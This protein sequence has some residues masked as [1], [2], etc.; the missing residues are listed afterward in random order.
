MLAACSVHSYFIHFHFIILWLPSQDMTAQNHPPRTNMKCHKFSPSIHYHSDVV[1][2]ISGYL[3]PLPP[4]LVHNKP[5]LAHTCVTMC[6]D[7]LRC[8]T[9]CYDVLLH[10]ML[11]GA[12]AALKRKLGLG[13]PSRFRMLQVSGCYTVDNEGGKVDDAREFQEM[14]QSMK[15]VGFEDHARDDMLTLLAAILHLSN[16]SFTPN[17][18]DESDGAAADA[19]ALQQAASILGVDPQALEKAMCFRTLTTMAAGGGVETY[20]VPQNV[21][22]AEAARDALAKDM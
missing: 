15:T 8:A 18:V 1:I 21:D 22:Q 20:Q 5:W 9:M 13:S 17:R 2:L 11:A 12:D 7:V 10:K 3:S 19:A 4:V 6:Y 14:L 16:V